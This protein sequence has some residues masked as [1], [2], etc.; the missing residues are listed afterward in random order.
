[1]RARYTLKL[2]SGR[3]VK[4][5][6]GEAY[7]VNFDDIKLSFEEH[8]RAVNLGVHTHVWVEAID[9][10]DTTMDIYNYVLWH[11]QKY[12]RRTTAQ[13]LVI[14]WELDEEEKEFEGPFVLYE[15]II[16]RKFSQTLINDIKFWALELHDVVTG[17]VAM[18]SL[19]EETVEF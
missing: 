11:L 9:D 13:A 18:R 12:P 4:I 17:Y 2:K 5:R 16:K 14:G 15:L 3:K 10:P 1:M 6:K 8:P 19:F 7:E